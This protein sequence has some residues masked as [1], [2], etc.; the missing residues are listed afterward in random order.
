MKKNHR[1]GKSH[2][3]RPLGEVQL[4]E[5]FVG[6]Q[7]AV[8][9]KIVQLM[10]DGKPKAAIGMI[11]RDQEGVPS[12]KRVFGKSLS[13]VLAEEGLKETT[14]EDLLNLIR[15]KRRIEEHLEQHP[16][17]VDSKKGLIRTSSKIR[18]LVKYYRRKSVLPEGWQESQQI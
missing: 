7:D 2:S 5:G 1:K 15:K 8:R 4:S 14:P 3:A 13:K 6:S 18:R 12:V 9:E 11:L 10:K 16:K 17:D